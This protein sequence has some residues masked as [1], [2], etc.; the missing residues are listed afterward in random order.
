MN[1]ILKQIAL[2]IQ[3]L[4]MQIEQLP[5]ENGKKVLAFCLKNAGKSFG[6]KYIDLGCAEEVNAVIQLV[7]GFQIGGGASTYLMYQALKDKKRFLKI[8]Q[9]IGGDVVISPTGYGNGKISGHVGIYV[10]DK[11]MSND[12]KTGKFVKNFTLQSWKNRYVVI[13]NLPMEYY[14][15]I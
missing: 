2:T 11:I 4:R 12:S 8:S 7:L 5:T 3:K 13:G 6:N 14:R 1:E 15:I 10:G 9:P